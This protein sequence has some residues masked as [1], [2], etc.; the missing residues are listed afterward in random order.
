[1]ATCPRL[2]QGPRVDAATQE[3]QGNRP[4]PRV[5]V[6]PCRVPRLQGEPTDPGG[7]PPARA[8]ASLGGKRSS[9]D[10][11]GA[12]ARGSRGAE[13]DNGHT[14]R[15]PGLR[16]AARQVLL[17]HCPALGE[18]LRLLDHRVGGLGLQVRGVAVRPQDPLH[19]DAQLG[20]HVLPQ[21]PVDRDLALRSSPS[22]RSHGGTSRG[23]RLGQAFEVVS[24][25][26]TVATLSPPGA[27]AERPEPL[28]RRNSG[29]DPR[30]RLTWGSRGS[31]PPSADYESAA[32]P[33]L[34]DPRGPPVSPETA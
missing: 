25:C 14:S 18:G 32:F 34:L 1:M 4:G 24:R 5:D 31:N 10:L 2:H 19:G 27:A 22:R 7:A 6:P 15:R 16:R 23:R 17:C 33:R 29:P 8:R 21:G 20:A 26:L 3:S 12:G 9:S 13:G 30:L 28:H 11:V